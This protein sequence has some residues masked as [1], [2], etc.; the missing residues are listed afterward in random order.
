MRDPGRRIGERAGL[1]SCSASAGQCYLGDIPAG[2]AAR[3]DLS[4]LALAL[5]PPRNAVERCELSSPKPRTRY[6]RIVPQYG[7]LIDLECCQ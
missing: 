2:D 6:A 4:I 5:F 7:L 1:T 3:W